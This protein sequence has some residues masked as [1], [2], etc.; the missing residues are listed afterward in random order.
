[1]T[2]RGKGLD[3][4]KNNDLER[5]LRDQLCIIQEVQL[6]SDQSKAENKMIGEPEG[7]Q[8]D[9]VNNDRNTYTDNEDE[10]PDE[11]DQDKQSPPKEQ[12]KQPVNADS[13]SKMY[14]IHPDFI[15]QGSEYRKPPSPKPGAIISPS[16][17]LPK[18]LFGSLKQSPK[19][20]RRNSVSALEL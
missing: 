20:Q 11:K 16:N 10:G 3:Q 15:K 19:I 8:G 18:Q 14:S 6:P 9:C 1:M 12:L 17:M 5:Y 2:F 7:G 4:E 13:V